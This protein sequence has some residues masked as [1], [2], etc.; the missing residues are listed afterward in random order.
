METKDMSWDEWLASRSPRRILIEELTDK[1]YD[2]RRELWVLCPCPDCGMG[3]DNHGRFRPDIRIPMLP[4]QA[5]QDMKVVP[6]AKCEG[7]G[8]LVDWENE[9]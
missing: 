3:S 5:I 1:F 6:C 8:F 4:G 7:K 9:R 2:A